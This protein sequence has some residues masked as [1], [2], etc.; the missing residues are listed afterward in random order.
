LRVDGAGLDYALRASAPSLDASTSTP[1]S[2]RLGS[3]AAG[4]FHA[5]GL[6]VDGEAYCWGANLSG[7]LGD[8]TDTDRQVPVRAAMGLTFESIR[9]GR[10]HSCA[11]AAGGQAYCWG[12]GTSGQLGN[13]ANSNS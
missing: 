5:C 8:G 3:L 6:T 12:L 7:R 2:V 13:G 10:S 4:G 11:I 9:P 1:F